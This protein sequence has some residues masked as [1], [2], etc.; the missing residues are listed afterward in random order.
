M[1]QRIRSEIQRRFH[2]FHTAH[3]E[4]LEALITTL[5]EA[6][7]ERGY[8]KWSIGGAYEVVRWTSPI[9]VNNFAF[10]LNNNFRSRYARMIVDQ[11]PDL[12]GFIEMRQLKS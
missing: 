12:D 8:Q 10:K 11:C 7:N 4:V 2:E 5:R 6:K 9:R 1:K 3:P